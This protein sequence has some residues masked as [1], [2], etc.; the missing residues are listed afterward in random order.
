MALQA[1]GLRTY[2]WN[3]NLKCVALLAG[4]PVLLFGVAYALLLLVQAYNAPT[5]AAGFANAAHQMPAAALA[6]LGVAGGWYGVAYVGHQ[7][8]IDIAA[9]SKALTRA[10][11]PE[12]YN[13]L[14][15]L[16][17]SRGLPT[18]ALR[19][20]ESPSLNAFAS[21]L[22]TDK[23]TVTVTRGLLDAL[24][25]PE[26]EAVLAHEL[27][28]IQNRDVRLLVIA[29][30]FVGIISLVG[31][32][33]FRGL[34][35]VRGPHRRG[36]RREG[37]GAAALVLVAFAVIALSYAL[38]IVVRFALSRRREFMADAGAVELT[39]NP[40]ALIAALRKVSAGPETERG[41]A[42]IREMY[43]DH[44]PKGFAA[45]FATHPP[46]EARIAA[47][48]RYAGATPDAQAQQA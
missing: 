5:V 16:C 48:Q 25:P 23:A 45:L 30:V 38:A 31:E 7:K 47:L 28:H 6:A 41:P 13:L 21:G 22:T 33:L 36:G 4:F 24:S 44:R 29:A 19:I 2:I 3:T 1:V 34:I 32:M 8:I 27:S 26:L 20:M 18:P 43:F 10:E 17:I 35:R 39:K 14:E 37:G 12:V 11:A 42:E 9:G 40:D 15:N 46:L